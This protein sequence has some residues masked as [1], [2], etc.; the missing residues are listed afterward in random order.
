[1][2]AS[3][4]AGVQGLLGLHLEGLTLAEPPKSG[5]DPEETGL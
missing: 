5:P 3:R 2:R 1:M 4:Q